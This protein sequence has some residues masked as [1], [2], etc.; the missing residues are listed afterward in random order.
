MCPNGLIG[1]PQVTCTSG[2]GF[3]T[4]SSNCS[5]PLGNF[6]P[7]YLVNLT[8]YDGTVINYV[9]FPG[10]SSN[11]PIKGICPP[12]TIGSQT[13]TCNNATQAWTVTGTCTTLPSPVQSL[14]VVNVTDTIVTLTWSPGAGDSRYNVSGGPITG[15][16]SLS[17]APVDNFKGQNIATTSL[18]VDQLTPSTQYAFVIYGGDSVGNAETAGTFVTVTTDPTPITPGNF[19]MAFVGATGVTVTWLTPPPTNDVPITWFQIQVRYFGAS[20]TRSITSDFQ[21]VVPY[22]TEL[23]YTFTNLIAES[24]YEVLILFGYVDPN[25]GATLLSKGGT[26]FEF[27]TTGYVAPTQPPTVVPT[28][29]TSS[30][31]SFN[32]VAPYVGGAIG[33]VAALIII[34]GLLVFFYIR[35]KRK[36]KELYQLQMADLPPAEGWGQSAT[37]LVSRAGGTQTLTRTHTLTRPNQGGSFDGLN[38]PSISIHSLGS[39]NGEMMMS[40]PTLMNTV[41]EIALPGFLLLDY[42]KDL[43]IVNRFGNGGSGVVYR[44]VL[45]DP[46]L[47]KQHNV[48]EVAIKEV[49]SWEKL[50]DEENMERF[51]QEVSLLWSLAFHRNIAT[52][53]GYTDVP[54]TIVTKL[55]ETDL[56]QFIQNPDEE[57]NLSINILLATQV[58][59]GIAAMHNIGIVHRDIKSA[60]VLLET[61]TT[62]NGILLNACLCDFGLARVTAASKLFNQKFSTVVGLSPRYAAPEV[63]AR[64]HL[65]TLVPDPEEEKKADVFAFGVVIWELLTRQV[66]WDDLANEQIELKIRSGK[67]LELPASTGDVMLQT[68]LDI[69][70]ASWIEHPL[71]RPSIQDIHK[72]LDSLHL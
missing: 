42:A 4:P 35:S 14:T 50:S 45:L 32:S 11:T 24:A 57:T 12:G 17:L 53:I 64:S 56:F 5:A 33:G 8:R 54:T 49:V 66:P 22:Y 58:S 9:Q 55:Y 48:E 15:E 31:P 59:A 10:T 3:S 60:N 38:Q 1:N 67:R 25:T 61:I 72:G 47:R 52:L 68:L 37:S 29:P 69:C 23:S 62:Q 40:D 51:H 39:T 26:S 6:C 34:V 2:T 28:L 65:P 70:T 44:A 46:K 13:A 63:F 30:P 41:M 21:V 36:E 19:T 71:K 20:A 43:R 7:Q 16:T 27:W 18:V